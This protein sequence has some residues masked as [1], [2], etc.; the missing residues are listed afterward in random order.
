MND[1]DRDNIWQRKVRDSVLAPGYYGL[2]STGGRY[3]FIDKGRLATILQKRFAVDTILQG[4]DGEAVCI[5][6][7]IVRWPGYRYRSYC[8]ETDSCTKPGHESQGWMHYGQADFLLYCFMQPD[9]LECHLIDFQKLK[10]WFW[11]IA[12]TLP[13][14]GPLDTINRSAGRKARIDVAKAAGVPVFVKHLKPNPA[15]PHFTELFPGACQT[16]LDAMEAA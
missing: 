8:L 9:Q 10:A 7:K 6:E 4:K 11:P 2:Y 16:L 3:V 15:D 1:F 12:S 14:F 5:E 13:S